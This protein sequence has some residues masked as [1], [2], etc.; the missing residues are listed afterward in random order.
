MTLVIERWDGLHESACRLFDLAELNGPTNP[1]A[2]RRHVLSFI[3][4][5]CRGFE[6]S[7]FVAK[8]DHQI[9]GFAMI[10]RGSTTGVANI[11]GCVH[12]DKRKQGL[13]TALLAHINDELP[14]Y[15][16]IHTLTTDTFQSCPEGI[17]FVQ[18]AGYAEHDRI[19]WSKRS[20]TPPF[21]EDA[22][23][24]YQALLKSSIRFV[25]ASE[26]ET[27]R[28]DWDVCWWTHHTEVLKDIPSVIPI[29]AGPFEEWRKGIEPPLADRSRILMALDG[30]DPV[31][32]LYLGKP[33]AG[34]CNINHTGVAASHRRR[35]LSLA[36]KIKAFELAAQLGAH[37]ITTQNHHHNPMLNINL[38]LGFDVQDVFLSFSKPAS[39]QK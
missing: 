37:F 29:E 8:I 32:S 6:N 33:E 7:A 30:L 13:G 18:K 4:N 1:A 39:G 9:W 31:G 23:Q 27:L 14:K 36:L 20:V 25:L 11:V 2:D 34:V 19:Y 38:Q 28:P 17:R 15:P 24:K 21:P 26:F 3:A 10:F 5:R 35:G 16:H 22:L 12:P